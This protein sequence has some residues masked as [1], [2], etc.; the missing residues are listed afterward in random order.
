VGKTTRKVKAKRGRPGRQAPASKLKATIAELRRELKDANERLTATSEVLTVLSSPLG[1]LQRTFQM[2]LKKATQVCGAEFGTLNLVDGKTYRQVAS[3]NTPRAYSALV[4]DVSFEAH[5]GSL[6]GR[7]MKTPRPVQVADIRKE[8]AYRD[9][10]PAV[11]AMADKAGA[12][13]LA[14]VPMLK[15]KTLVGTIAIYRKEVHPFSDKQIGVLENFAS[16]AVIAIE[17]AR[18]FNET[19]ETLQQQTATADVLKLISRSAFDLQVVLATLI[20]SAAR[21][22]GA[23]Q[24]T[25][26]LRDG[27]AMRVEA[28]FGASRE[29]F[30]FLK[31]NPIGRDRSTFTGRTFLTGEVTHLPDVLADPEY[32]LIQAPAIGRFRSA[33][34]VPLL[35]DGR[36]EGVFSLSKVEPVGFTPREIELVRTFADQAVIAISNTRL[37]NETREALERQTA[38]ADILKV[39][40]SSPSDAGPVFAAIADRSNQLVGGHSTTVF[41]FNNDQVEIAA[42]TPIS[43]EADLALQTAFPRSFAEYPLWELLRT[44]QITQIEDT[45]ALSPR[46]LQHVR[47]PRNLAGLGRARGYRSQLY[48]PLLTQQGPIGLISVT[49]KEPGTFAQHHVQLLQ[50]FADQA[51]IAIENSRLFNETKEA[52]E[53]QTATTDVLKV[54][55]SS[56]SNLQPV[57]DAIAERSNRLIGGHSTAVYRFADGIVHPGRVYA[58]EPGSR[59]CA[60][61]RLPSSGLGNSP[62]F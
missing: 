58:G 8:P 24:G 57:F 19:Q 34:A 31:A 28:H 43:P 51:V 49:R 13:T 3:F 44:G 41:R 52:L 18:L 22:C 23:S 47:D 1:N 42:F 55:A 5:P 27:D 10:H 4:R 45:E 36:V 50:T 53:R 39:I 17:N 20:E 35:R 2:L 54:I 59:R 33:L 40:A 7:I 11:R 56:P 46:L 12:R 25:V 62:R 37:F 16:Q 21:L 38:T 30:D 15:G 9:G 32:R 14:I 48:I 26:F 60:A 29:F 61:K 6:H